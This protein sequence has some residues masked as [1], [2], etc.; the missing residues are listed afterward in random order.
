M[1]SR[2]HPSSG[3]HTP[4]HTPT[5]SHTPPT[6]TP[7]HHAGTQPSAPAAPPGN[8]QP[9]RPDDDGSPRPT[10]NTR[11]TGDGSSDG[12]SGSHTGS[13][14]G[15]GA[16]SNTG[17]GTGSNTGD[18]A[19]SD[20]GA[21][22][23]ADDGADPEA[24]PGGWKGILQ[25][26]GKSAAE[27][28]GGK[29]G[30]WAGDKMF[31]SGEDSQSGAGG[32]GAGA[33]GAA[34]PAPGYSTLPYPAPSPY[35]GAVPPAGTSSSGEAYAWARSL[36]PAQS[37]PL[38]AASHPSRGGLGGML[39]EAV[40]YALEKSGLMDVLEK[41][42]GDLAQ[43]NAAAEEWQAQAKAVT[44]I[45][46]ELRRSAVP[47]S[48]Q[49]EGQAS[50]AF[51]GHMGKV[52]EALDSTAAGMLKT[53]QIINSAAQEC[54]MA[55]GMIVEIISEAIEALIVSLAA[56]AV[57]AVLT[58]GI[59]LIADA[60][61]TEAEITVF[62]ARVAR[63]SEELATKLEELLKALKELGSA[64]KAVKNIESA[65]TALTS[66]KNVKTAAEGIRT[67][68][69]GGEGA[70]KL[71]KEIWQ[72]KSVEGMGD[73][74]KDFGLRQGVKKADSYVTG[75]AEEGVK[76]GLGI[77]SEDPVERGDLSG[78]GLGT[79]AGKSAWGAAKEGLTGD[80]NIEAV[81]GEFLH[82]TGFEDDPEPYRVDRSKVDT[83][84][85]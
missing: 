67:F 27:G 53:A 13:N 8:T 66:L 61:I 35:P 60:L 42:T 3:S 85:G 5:P 82:D 68:E 64:V 2:H 26:A 39:D 81:K 7:D 63:V 50:D 21:G 10:Q 78:K 22:D 71:G 58:A 31:G 9:A 79:A 75:K 34:A 32:E 56:E 29:A 38:A 76:A 48:Q 33:G 52:V 30:E 47:L 36:S 73:R 70:G 23:G 43:L 49:W 45:S 72:N 77:D 15:D 65:K 16:G 84:F 57:I 24:E 37:A 20:A 25:G 12:D 4:M 83:P 44:R 62:V 74:L 18:D 54:A 40:E 1:S 11:G 55:E 41:V 17:S 59:G 6:P 51:G 14:T 80:T 46:E 69:E 28:L 19:G